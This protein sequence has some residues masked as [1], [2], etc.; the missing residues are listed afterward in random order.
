MSFFPETAW[1]CTNSCHKKSKA[2]AINNAIF[3]NLSNH[4]WWR[5][6]GFSGNNLF[7]GFSE[8]TKNLWNNILIRKIFMLI[9]MTWLCSEY[10]QE[11]YLTANEYHVSKNKFFYILKE[12]MHASTDMSPRKLYVFTKIIFGVTDWLPNLLQYFFICHQEK[13]YYTLINGNY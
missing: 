7:K 6:W 10:W 5:Y 8:T 13:G 1:K 12:W 11:S 9:F 3:W 2:I 4:P